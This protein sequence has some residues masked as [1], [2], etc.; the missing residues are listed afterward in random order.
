MWGY[1]TIS[2]SLQRTPLEALRSA[3]QKNLYIQEEWAYRYLKK[4]IKEKYKVLHLRSDTSM[5]ENK[6]KDN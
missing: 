4:F 3:I 6:L 1:R 2:A 5:Q